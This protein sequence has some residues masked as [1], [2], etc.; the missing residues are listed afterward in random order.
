MDQKINEMINDASYLQELMQSSYTDA[1]SAYESMENYDGD[2][3]YIVALN[4]LLMS[5]Q[6][7]IELKRLLHEKELE[8]YELAPFFTS[9]ED[10]K[11]QLKKVIEDKDR[12][13]SWLY[14]AYNKLKENWISANE[15]LL[16]Y[17]KTNSEY[18]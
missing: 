8:H 11:F 13:T 15:F 5:Q 4:F 7:Y 12:N 3:R 2:A 9:Y 18:R 1:L 17:I 6:S 16:N 14:S 10:Y